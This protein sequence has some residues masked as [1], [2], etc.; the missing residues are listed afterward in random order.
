MGRPQSLA[1]HVTP[2]VSDQRMDHM[3]SGISERMSEREAR[4]W[5]VSV[6]PGGQWFLPMSAVAFA[7]AALLVVW[8]VT[9]GSEARPSLLEG[10]ALETGSDR[11]AV[12]LNDGS[13]LTLAPSSRVALEE[14]GQREVRLLLE[15]GA[16]TCEVEPDED[17]DF[18]VRA[19]GVN[20][21]VVGTIFRVSRKRDVSGE[22]VGVNVERGTVEVT[23][24]DGSVRR[25]SAGESWSK[26]PSPVSDAVSAS[27]LED[28]KAP[29]A[30]DADDMAKQPAVDRPHRTAPSN[31]GLDSFAR[32]MEARR[33][34]RAAE[35]ASLFSQFIRKHP[36]DG[37]AGVAAF[38]LGRLRMDQLG[39]LEGAARMLSVAV[40]KGAGGLQ[41][42]ALARLVRARAALG[43]K[44]GCR[45]ARRSYLE[46]FPSGVHIDQV[47]R[48]CAK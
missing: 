32:A 41:D 5:R 23:G 44:A 45:N 47:K 8:V 9:P 39:D 42:D 22:H 13:V 17:R 4:T 6:R 2:P 1:E 25:L 12:D 14:T 29:D 48:L 19:G 28:A 26:R 37:R 34:G 33:K 7:F 16:V 21:R 38:E 31:K 43:D 18:V 46:S 10:A 36:S 40:E 24:Q 3:W 27:S 20:V 11:M 30:A 35:A 15:R